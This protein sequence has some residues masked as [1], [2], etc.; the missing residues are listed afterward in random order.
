M[1]TSSAVLDLPNEDIE[2]HP[3]WV[4]VS[5]QADELLEGNARLKEDAVAHK[6][7]LR[8]LRSQNS[9]QARIIE[10]LQDELRILQRAAAEV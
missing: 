4:S 3:H 5:V 6:L 2:L 7:M 9:S 10:T 8:R 1:A